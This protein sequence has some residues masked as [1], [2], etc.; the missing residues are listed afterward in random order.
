MD[1][2]ISK[3]RHSKEK[4]YGT[5]MLV[6]GILIWAIAAIAIIAVAMLQSIAI[7]FMLALYV[8]IFW[9]IG[10]VGRALFAPI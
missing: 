3:V 6:I 9:F 7:V 8:A 10:F 5:V 2:K 1:F 4:L